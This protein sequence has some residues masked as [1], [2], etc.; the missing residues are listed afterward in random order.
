MLD[1]NK[2]RV[3]IVG[4]IMLDRYWEGNTSR[5]S[6]E[7]PVPVV[8]IQKDYDKVGGAGNVAVNIATLGGE[9]SVLALVGKDASA[10][11]LVT[12]LEQAQV[13]PNFVTND[14][15]PTIT[16]LR[17]LSQ[18]QQL[19]RADFE[20]DFP[21]ASLQQIHKQFSKLLP[22]ANVVVISDYGKGTLS[23]IPTLIKQAKAKNIPVLVD[24]K[25]NDFANYHG[26]T[27]ITP[28]YKEFI[29]AVGPC[30]DE[31]ELLINAKQLIKQHALG[32]LL[33]TR[34]AQ[35]MTLILADQAKAINIPAK[36]KE[37]FDVTGAG[38]TV[39][40]T[41][42]MG[43]GAGYEWESS[44]Q[45]ANAA[46]SIVVGK[47]GTATVSQA[48]LHLALHS[49]KKLPTGI[50]TTKD[51]V[52]TINLAKLQGDKI[53]MTNGCFDL[54]HPGHIEYLQQAYAMGD[55]LVVAINTDAS[56]KRLKGDARPINNLEHRMQMLAALSCVD[57][58]VAFS[59]DTPEAII[60]ELMPNVL[61]KGADYKVNEIAGAK[62][63]IA[64]G[65]EVKTI[66]LTPE[67]STSNLIKKI[68]QLR[69]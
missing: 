47:V 64:N 22:Q 19:I 17:L 67:C 48:E 68:Q 69:P 65:G 4:D 51:T 3:L 40:A 28:N 15:V 29:A 35:G 41:M 59:T 33:I 57:W 54:L 14:T 25:S 45:Y 58:V 62:P 44:M 20:S 27:L 66:K 32:G 16:K 13:Q 7:A 6:P 52:A 9:A 1:F 5:I 53:V 50:M 61:V 18:H 24:P 12:L 39:I 36:A 21:K 26:A 63:V 34:G 43:C 31:Q 42:A 56:V 60:T 46:A 10:K 55:R 38:D 2:A 23:E 8:H 37:V 49:T 30:Q 11:K